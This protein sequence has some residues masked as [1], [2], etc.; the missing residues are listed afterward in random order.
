[1]YVNGVDPGFSGDL[2]PLAAL[3]LTGRAE[4]VLVQEIC[5][6][7]SY[8]DAEFTGVSFG[9][10]TDPGHVA[11]AVPARCAG[12]HLGWTRAPPGRRARRRARRDPRAARD[13]GG[14]RTD[15]LHDD[16]GR[17]R[18]G[19]RRPVRRRGNRRRPPRHRHGARQPADGGRGTRLARGRPRAG[20]ASTASSSPAT[21]ASRSTP[22]SASTGSTTTSPASWPPRPRRSTPSRRSAPRPRAWSLRDLPVSQVR[23]L[24][25]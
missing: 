16:A 8:D 2:L 19:G 4:T 11:D 12:L 18:A 7:G 21:P 9:F 25:R 22:T 20:P 13:V 23:G 17:A 1:M 14:N 3:S 6:Y 5:D 24:M 15:R 10:G